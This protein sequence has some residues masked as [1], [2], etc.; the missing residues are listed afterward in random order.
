[1]LLAVFNINNAIALTGSN[2][3]IENLGKGF[4]CTISFCSD[5][6]TSSTNAQTLGAVT[7]SPAIE[8]SSTGYSPNV[9]NIKSGSQVKLKIKNTGGSGC[10]QTFTIPG[11]GIQKSVPIGSNDTIAFTAPSTPGQLPFMCSMGMYRGMFNV[12]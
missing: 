3:T 4:W 2:L 9:I 10:T 12:I 6:I 11:L 8:I 1:M 5:E 7:D